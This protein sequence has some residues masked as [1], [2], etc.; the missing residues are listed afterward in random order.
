MGG[1]SPDGG[2]CAGRR[3]QIRAAEIHSVKAHIHACQVNLKQA[4]GNTDLR[5][6][7]SAIF[8]QGRESLQFSNSQPTEFSPTSERTPPA[9]RKA[10]GIRSKPS[11]GLGVFTA[12]L[13]MLGRQFERFFPF[14]ARHRGNQ[15]SQ[16]SRASATPWWT[17][18]TSGGSLP[19]GGR[20]YPRGWE[21]APWLWLLTW[22]HSDPSSP[23]RKMA[24]LVVRRP[25][26]GST[27]QASGPFFICERSFARPR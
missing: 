18:L 1:L 12:F 13:D 24:G 2:D 8:R 26:T 14:Q 19:W 11:P 10:V 9:D 22:S 3:L 21:I 4:T 20:R 7:H 6:E 27:V 5:E 17:R 15:N 16:I 23:F 25:W